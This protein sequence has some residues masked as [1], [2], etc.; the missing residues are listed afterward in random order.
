MSCAEEASSTTS[1]HLQELGNCAVS[2]TADADK[3][4]QCLLA[5]KLLQPVQ[6]DS[7][8]SLDDLIHTQVTN[9]YSAQFL[10]MHFNT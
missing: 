7:K 9:R 6:M 2:T 8:N 10:L 3:N 5:V 1:L 4:V